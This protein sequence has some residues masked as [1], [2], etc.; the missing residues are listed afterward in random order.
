ML[1]KIE[2]LEK[3]Q[4]ELSRAISSIQTELLYVFQK[5]GLVRYNPFQEMGGD[6]SFSIALL[7]QENDGFVL[8]SH[9]GRNAQRLYAKPIQAGKSEYQL[10]EEEEEAIRL[11]ISK[12]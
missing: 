4:K 1:K 8:T 2:A 7:T 3:Q 6:Q 11:A 5:I 10:S 9:F 12:T